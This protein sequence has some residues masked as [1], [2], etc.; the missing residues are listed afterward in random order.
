MKK[1]LAWTVLVP[2][3]SI[4][5]TGTDVSNA[6]SLAQKGII[7]IQSSER[8][9][10]LD[11]KITRAEVIGIALKIKW[12][13]LPEDYKCRKYFSDTVKQDWVCRA[14][15]LASDNELISRGN[16]KA[17]PQDSITRAEAFSILFKASTLTPTKEYGTFVSKDLDAAQWQKDLFVKVRNSEIEI[18][19]T[20]YLS[21]SSPETPYKFFPN[22]LATRAEIFG[23]GSKILEGWISK[24]TSETEVGMKTITV[25]DGDS[26][27]YGDLKIRMIGLDAPESSTTRYGYIECFGLQ[28]SEYLKILLKD[29]KELT[30]ELD[31]TQGETDKYGRTLAYIFYNGINLNT[32]MILDGYA[33]EYT[34]DK[35]YKYQSDNKNAELTAKNAGL[36]LWSTSTCWGDRKKWTQVETTNTTTTPSTSSYACG[37]KTYC[38]E[39]VTCEEAKYY[40][41]SC[42]LSRLD[43]DKDG[44]PC[45]AICN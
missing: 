31:P 39:M 12:T 34:Y 32:K 35:A 43:G 24:T 17:R 11:E 21:S 7:T 18:P 29:A 38:S 8:D 40:L 5:Y 27:R 9:Y 41:N 2:F 42:G 3:L 20:E 22:R 16:T 25:V 28:A 44:T 33:F 14:I 13:T 4:A 23:F 37:S 1:F 10:R 19:W 15:E 26:I 36:G 30:I 45:E 6:T